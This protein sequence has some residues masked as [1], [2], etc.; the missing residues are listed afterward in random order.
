VR[1]GAYK[2]GVAGGI[3]TCHGCGR[4]LSVIGTGDGRFNYG[5]RR[6]SSAG[7]CP[8]PTNVK[9]DAA[10]TFVDEIVAEALDGGTIDA[11]AA[12][13]AVDEA[14]AAWEAAKAERAALTSKVKPS[15]PNFEAWLADADA[16][17][18]AAQ[19]VYEDASARAGLSGTLP[20][21]ADYLRMSVPDR[22]RIARVL[23]AGIVVSRPVSRSKL[24]D[25]R[26]R[27]T[28]DWR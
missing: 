13:R 9:K 2:A 1:T 10:D 12:T 22:N 4:P 8:S 17:V 23:L 11:V 26:A 5:C 28:P 3:L 6:Q 19:S 7:A 18:D 27:F 25:I 16:D 15:H 24:A 21:R 20:A 14:K